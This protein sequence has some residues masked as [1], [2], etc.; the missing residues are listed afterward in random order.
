MIARSGSTARATKPT[1]VNDGQ[2]LTAEPELPGFRVAAGL[3]F[4]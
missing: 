1:L 4:A 3:L 2:D